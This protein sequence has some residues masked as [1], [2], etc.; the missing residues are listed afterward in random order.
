MD[1]ISP[2]DLM[3]QAVIH[4]KTATLSGQVALSEPGASLATQ[5]KEV[6]GRIDTILES[7]GTC[8][9]RLISATIWLTDPCDFAEFNRLW[10]AW[11]NG[12]TPPARATVRADLVMP[13]LLLEV[14]VS[15][16]T[17]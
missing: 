14:Q 12:A 10:L 1:H 9:A 11:L 17:D 4:N 16:A 6:F 2:N 7:C 8:R 15:A 3:S 13:G 5:A